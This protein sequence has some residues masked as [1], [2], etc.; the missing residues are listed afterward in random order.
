MRAYALVSAIAPDEAADVYLRR[1][2]AEVALA[3]CL[4]DEPDLIDIVNIVPMELDERTSL[5]PSSAYRGGATA[6]KPRAAAP[7]DPL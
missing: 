1:E 7:L 4:R 2:D 5:R 6:E 3:E